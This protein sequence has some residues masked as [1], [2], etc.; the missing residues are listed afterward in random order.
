MSAA[1]VLDFGA[2]RRAAVA[3]RQQVHL[4]HEPQTQALPFAPR[5]AQQ[6][7]LWNGHCVPV[8]DFG[9]WAGEAPTAKTGLL[10]IYA[11]LDQAQGTHQL[12]GLWLAA[13]PVRVE[14]DDALA[15][16]LPSGRE[17]WR[18]FSLSC[19]RDPRLGTLPIIDLAQV[20]RERHA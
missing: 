16:E 4:A 15:C 17:G 7:L 20:F 18:S 2:D 1:W 19:F 9:A 3:Q 5:A 8:I 6:L 10:G 11:Y 14:V 12:G 13:P